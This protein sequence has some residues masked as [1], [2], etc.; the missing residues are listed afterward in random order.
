MVGTGADAPWRRFTARM[1]A[2]LRA[3]L[4]GD[5]Q[6]RGPDGGSL[7]W[8]AF[9]DLSQGRGIGPAGPDA[10]RLTEVQAWAA[11]NAT[12]LAPRHVAVIFALDDV[13]LEH[14]RTRRAPE[15]AKVLPAMSKG[16]LTPTLFDLTT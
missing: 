5:T 10:L 14:V 3:R 4:D 16:R 12:P 13:W 7:F 11:L 6:V 2:G 1:A 8:E 15:G 9:S